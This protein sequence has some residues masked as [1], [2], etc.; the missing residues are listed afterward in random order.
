M[1]KAILIFFL[2]L[3]FSLNFMD[4]CKKYPRPKTEEGIIVEAKICKNPLRAL[5]F[6]FPSA[7]YK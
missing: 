6:G 3:F 7:T 2:I 4:V 5:I 1:T